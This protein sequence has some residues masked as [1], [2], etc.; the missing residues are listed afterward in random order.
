MKFNTKLIKGFLAIVFILSFTFNSTLSY[1]DSSNDNNNYLTTQGYVDYL[2]EK[3]INGD[4]S[5]NE[6]LE[7]FLN[8]NNSEQEAFLKFLGSSD[9][10]EFFQLGASSSDDIVEKNYEVDGVIVP[11]TYKKESVGD[12]STF[13][14]LAT[15]VETSASHSEKITIFGIRTTT[16]T[17]TVN[18]EHNGRVA[19]K[20]LL[21]KHSHANMNPAWIISEQSNTHPGYLT[22]DGYYHGSGSWTMSSTG[23]VGA[24][25]HTL[26]IAIKGTTPS[27]KYWN[28]TSSHPSLSNSP[29]T[30]F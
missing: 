5:A 17:L 19:T 18:W 20:A 8:L 6:V 4:P 10:T 3:I 28:F 29:W 1:A 13:N 2:Q 30:K 27:N 14:T 16:I 21:V 24:L 23:A 15:S 9:Y 25:S 7:Q 22:S 26:S 12:D 11:V